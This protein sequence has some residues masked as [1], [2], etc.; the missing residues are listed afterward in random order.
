MPQAC[1]N[2]GRAIAS[3]GLPALP[4][5][6]PSAESG[7]VST[8]RVCAHSSVCEIHRCGKQGE[9][10]GSKSGWVNRAVQVPFCS[11]SFLYTV[12]AH[13]R[14]P[15]QPVQLVEVIIVVI[16]HGQHVCCIVVPGFHSLHTWWFGRHFELHWAYVVETQHGFSPAGTTPSTHPTGLSNMLSPM[17]HPQACISCRTAC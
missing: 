15:C 7:F 6:V 2:F 9:A 5:C 4:P 17:P 11:H 14:W 16:E 10:A 13:R 12:G 8:D 1:P 3:R